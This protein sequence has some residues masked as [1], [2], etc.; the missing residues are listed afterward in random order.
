VARALRAGAQLQSYDTRVSLAVKV[1]D[2]R[3][4]I[5]PRWRLSLPQLWAFVAITLPVIASLAAR[6][7]T[8]DLAYQIRAGLAMVATHALPRVDTFTYTVR[9]RPWLDQQWGA[10][11]LLALGFRGGGWSGLVVLRAALIG[12]IFSFVYASCRA[13]GA[14]RRRA[15]G[16]TIAAF[17]IASPGLNLRPQ[18]FAMLLFTV[19]AWIIVHR[20]DRPGW[21]LA[22]PAI[23]AVWAN[24]HGSFFLAPLLI[25]LA[26]LQ[27]RSGSP[28][29]AR[30][31]ALVG[32]ASL[33][34]TLL[35]PFGIRVW[36]YVYDISTSSVI[37]RFISEW[38]P[39]TIRTYAGAAFFL[40]V[41]AVVLVLVRR[42]E[43]VPWTSLLALGVF[44]TIALDAQRGIVWWAFAVPPILSELLA[45]LPRARSPEEPRAVNSL[46]AIALIG[47]G[48]AFAPWWRSQTPEG[49][50]NGL[51]SFAPPGIT[52]ELGT[53][54][55][56]GQRVF[57]SQAWG[58]WLEFQFRRNPVEADARIELFPAG[59]WQRYSDVSAGRQGWQSILSAWRVDVVVADREQQAR[60]LPL[61]EHDPGWRRVY[62]DK[63]GEIFVSSTGPADTAP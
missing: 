47:I 53:I 7:S 55:Q 54:L 2:R 42:T 43:T 50:P 59:V 9:G 39:P 16:L 27:D 12:G 20:R 56:P 22:I 11:V 40:S 29:R 48:I 51:L 38:E 60:L 24:L 18:L 49:G 41:A 26:W 23:T 15:A 46:L 31:T 35:N 52:R 13:A 34:A 57:G 17:A 37:T 44:F 58:S 45:T 63:D 33:A 61:I 8:V 1:R 21:M 62:S 5:A 10:Q 36:T 6:L 3:E 32:V 30:R 19:V 4:T 14:E 25:G 28:S